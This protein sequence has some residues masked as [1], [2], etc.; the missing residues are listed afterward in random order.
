MP[1]QATDG[2]TDRPA[3]GE[4]RERDAEVAPAVNFRNLK[5]LGFYSQDL[6]AKIMERRLFLYESLIFEKQ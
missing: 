3:N 1:G 4:L 2:P 6:V 5:Q